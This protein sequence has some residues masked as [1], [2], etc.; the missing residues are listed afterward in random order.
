MPRLCKLSHRNVACRWTRLTVQTTWTSLPFSRCASSIAVLSQA[1][2][3]RPPCLTNAT[4]WTNARCRN[5]RK[6]TCSSLIASRRSPAKCSPGKQHLWEGE[7]LRRGHP[8][9]CLLWPVQPSIGCAA[10]HPCPTSTAAASGA[11]KQGLGWLKPGAP[12]AQ[13][14]V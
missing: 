6:G 11:L 4:L 8:T 1:A 10:W 13:L 9:T 2:Q 7:P 14:D 3:H 12:F 5:S